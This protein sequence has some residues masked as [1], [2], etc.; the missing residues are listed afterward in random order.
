MTG[1]IDWQKGNGLIPAIAQDAQ[2]GHVLML[3]Y[4]NSEA[5]EQTK[6]TGKVTFFSRSKNRLWVK[7]ETSGN[8]LN[9]K[10]IHIDCDSDAIL[11]LVNP[12]GPAC[13]RDTLSC[14]DDA[15]PPLSFLSKLQ[16]II[17]ARAGE[18]TD[19]SY[20]AK[21]LN[22]GIGKV[23]QKVGEEGVETVLAA[24][25]ETPE[26]FL[27]E[28]ADLLFHMMIL[29]HAKGKSIEDIVAVLENRNK[30]KTGS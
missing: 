7:G 14:F 12:A 22:K 18:P 13:H 5:L 26:R 2:T 30:A 27:E 24:T 21:L 9:L 28:S 29:L 8:F 20:V 10:S 11:L 3:G 16:F 19:N 15:E 23:A 6:T 17:A 4:M 1:A 25:S